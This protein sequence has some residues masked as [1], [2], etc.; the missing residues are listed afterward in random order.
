MPGSIAAGPF[1]DVEDKASTVSASGGPAVARGSFKLPNGLPA[2]KVRVTIAPRQQSDRYAM[3]SVKLLKGGTEPIT[4]CVVYY[5]A[6]TVR[7]VQ[8]CFCQF[9]IGS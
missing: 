2:A 5:Q 4:G 7:D 9:Q 1:S 8:R 3:V 6:G